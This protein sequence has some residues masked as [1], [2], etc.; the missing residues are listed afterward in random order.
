MPAPAAPTDHLGV[1]LGIVNLA[2]DSDGATYSGDQVREVRERRFQH[3]RRLQLRNTR[4]A[5]RRL[6]TA[7][8]REARCQ[9]DTNH[10]ISKTLVAKAT[11]ERKALVLEDLIGIRARAT[12]VHRA[13]RRVRHRWAFFQL[14]TFIV[15]KA[16]QAGVPVLVVDPRNTSRTCACCGCCDQRNRQTQ[17]R[18]SCICCG[19]APPADVYAARSIAWKARVAAMSPRYAPKDTSQL[20]RVAQPEVQAHRL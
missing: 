12:V 6:R 18:F 2:A 14:R 3:R 1:D 8:R 20:R 11:R 13:Q 19:H 15:Y 16:A 17:S 10:R 5:K 4:N 9:R 7:K